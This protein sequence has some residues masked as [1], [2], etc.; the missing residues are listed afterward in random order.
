MMVGPSNNC[1]LMRQTTIMTCENSFSTC[2]VLPIFEASLTKCFLR[3]TGWS[4]YRS[5]KYTTWVTKCSIFA[6]RIFQP[7]ALFIPCWI[8]WPC[9]T[10]EVGWW[11]HN[12]SRLTRW[13]L[14]SQ[15]N[16][17]SRWWGWHRTNWCWVTSLRYLTNGQIKFEQ[18]QLLT[19]FY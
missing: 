6:N 3:S 7:W 14:W 11:E 12:S 8:E 1:L 9:L 13:G 18:R 15:C 4:T 17:T 2:S 10:W 19:H 16:I 5:R